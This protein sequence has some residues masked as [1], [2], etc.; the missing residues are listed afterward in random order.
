MNHQEF[1][2]TDIMIDLE[3]FGLRPKGLIVS[4]GAVAFDSRGERV[5]F[6]SKD[7][8]F[9]QALSVEALEAERLAG[10]FEIH[11]GTEAWWAKQAGFAKLWGEM[12]SSPLDTRGLL[13][14]FSDWIEPLAQSGAQVWGNAPSFDLVLLEHAFQQE[15]MPFPVPFRAE[16]DFRTLMGL[17]H[18]KK[19][20][21][22]A[23]LSHDALFDAKF[24]A[25]LCS[26]ALAQIRRWKAMEPACGLDAEDWSALGI[27][28]GMGEKPRM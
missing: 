5:A 15:G 23:D 21:P 25:V 16:Q 26:K 10:R 18:G 3:T 28:S 4:I 13:K 8:E 22:P 1:K 11:A 20:L 19:P 6:G 2:P 24:Q 17:I 27:G 9:Q 7:F 12:M 14:S